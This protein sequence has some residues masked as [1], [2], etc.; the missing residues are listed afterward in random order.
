MTLFEKEYWI[1]L[2]DKSL[3][4]AEEIEKRIVG[5]D[6][7]WYLDCDGETVVV[8]VEAANED[9]ALELSARK[10]FEAFKDI[11]DPELTCLPPI[12]AHALIKSFDKEKRKPKHEQGY[13][14]DLGTGY[15][16]VYFTLILNADAEDAVAATNAC[17][18]QLEA[19]IKRQNM[20]ARLD[21][22]ARL[23]NAHW[24][25]KS[26]YFVN[27]TIGVRVKEEAFEINMVEKASL[28]L[29]ERI[30]ALKVYAELDDA[31]GTSLQKIIKYQI[32]KRRDL[33]CPKSGPNKPIYF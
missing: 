22:P 9:E 8:P 20:T 10:V 18:E 19:I 30:K 29:W 25:N 17:N 12:L 28:R 5:T 16:N 27:Y 14:Q 3:N 1:T 24:L 11:C 23:Q 32:P 13:I 26:I 31:N 21:I 33:N 4:V 2:S 15:C 7:K 6:M